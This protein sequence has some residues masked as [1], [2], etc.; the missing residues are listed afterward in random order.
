MGQEYNRLTSYLIYYR[1]LFN[2]L[3]IVTTNK[4]RKVIDGYKCI[5]I[6]EM[7]LSYM[8]YILIAVADWQEV[9]DSLKQFGINDDQMIRSNVF[10]NPFFD[11]DEYI[12]LR[13]NK[14]SILSNFCVGGMIYK[15]LGL[16]M[17]SPT[18]DM[19]CL[20]DDYINFLKN[21]EELLKGEMREYI[22]KDYIKGTMGYEYFTPKGILDNQ[23][24]WY[25]NHN[26]NAS[27]AIDKWNERVKRFNFENVVALMTIQTDEEAYK[28]NELPI[29]KKLGIYYKDLTL[30]SVIYCPYWNE[31]NVRF[32]Y[33]GNWPAYANR[34]MTNIYDNVPGA[35]DWIK[36]LNGDKNFKRFE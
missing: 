21:Y 20:G 27:D 22:S 33:R 15:E 35:I 12:K 24:I 32:H 16:K 4:E 7:N 2:I 17:R 25:F 28:F 30:E 1:E 13:N 6:E 3:G 31:S 11:F 23:I 9:K 36:F 10:Y 8:D 26:Q 34:Y 19:Y 14:I 5:T 29:K 18:I